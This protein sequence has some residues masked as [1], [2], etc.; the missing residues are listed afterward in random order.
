MSPNE[1]HRFSL[2]RERL[3]SNKGSTRWVMEFQL[4]S[5]FFK[6]TESWLKPVKT[7]SKVFERKQNFQQKTE[8]FEGIHWTNET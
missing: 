3:E 4:F 7:L 6:K 1:K 5:S 2:F 8:I